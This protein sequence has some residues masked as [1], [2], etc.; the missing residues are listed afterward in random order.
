[1]KTNS[2]WFLDY[3]WKS[4]YLPS[5]TPFPFAWDGPCAYKHLFWNHFWRPGVPNPKSTGWQEDRDA[6]FSE[7]ELLPCYHQIWS[8]DM[9]S[10]LHENHSI[11]TG[12]LTCPGQNSTGK[13]LTDIQYIRKITVVILPSLKT[14]C[15]EVTN[16]NTYEKNVMWYEVYVINVVHREQCAVNKPR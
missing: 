8:K 12:L 6:P 4:I 1:M 13:F 5:F 11:I 14:D 15:S 9:T 2:C 16:L 10:D 3:L 7:L